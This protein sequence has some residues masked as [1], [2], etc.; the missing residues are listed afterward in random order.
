MIDYNRKGTRTKAD[1]EKYM[2]KKIADQDKE[3]KKLLTSEQYKKHL[4]IYK[5]VIMT[6]INNRLAS[7]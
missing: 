4:E 6:P 5:E 2:T 7:M 3:L 1:N